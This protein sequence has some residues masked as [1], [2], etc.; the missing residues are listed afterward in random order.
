MAG[1]LE[2]TD[3][4]LPSA[5]A[6]RI[7]AR[8]AALLP[9][10]SPFEDPAVL[11]GFMEADNCISSQLSGGSASVQLLITQSNPVALQEILDLHPGGTIRRIT[12]KDPTIH[13]GKYSKVRRHV[14]RAHAQID[15]QH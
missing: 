15:V 13:V 8:Y 6:R 11:A 7:P 5:A 2:L 1:D 3:A 10:S 9:A 4:D 12:V 14:P